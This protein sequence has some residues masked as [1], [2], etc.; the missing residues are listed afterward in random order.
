MED[1]RYEAGNTVSRGRRRFW[2]ALA[3]TVMAAAAGTALFLAGSRSNDEEGRPVPAP[4]FGP[5]SASLSSE[6]ETQ[7][8]DRVINLTEEEFKNAQFK[9][10]LAGELRSENLPRD[11]GLRTTGNIQSNAYRETAVIAL[12]GGVV[13]QVN[14][15]LGDA[16]REGQNLATVFSTELADA[17]AMY[18]KA[19]AEMEQHHRHH[20]RTVELVEIGAVSREEL[21]EATAEYKTAEAAVAS[22]KQRLVLLGMND[23]EAR[24]L[25]S[26]SRVSSLLRVT[27]PSSGTVIARSANPGLVVAENEELLR[28]ADLRTVWVVAQVYESDLNVVRVGMPATI[29][30]PAY[31]GRT[32]HGRVS[33]IAPIV[34]AQT[35][36]A[37]VRIELRNPGEALKLNMFVDV[38]FAGGIPSGETLAAVPKNA[39]QSIGNKQFVFLA[40]SKPGVFIQREVRVGPDVNGAV[41]V[42][43]GLSAGDRVVTEGSFLLRAESLKINPNQIDQASQARIPEARNGEPEIQSA[44]IVLTQSGYRPA[45]LTLRAGV[46]AKLTFVREVEATCGTEILIPRYGIRRELPPGEQVVVEFTPGEGEFEFTCGMSML[47]GKVVVK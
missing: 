10:E 8:G 2:P 34:D 29:T 37:Q 4:T 46:P 25:D 1:P 11:A 47:R 23:E 16:V 15:E 31:P 42:Y 12:V 5:S 26:A 6:V 9:I 27:A 41:A 3:L 38:R 19:L 7:P 32:F 45:S 17:Q 20:K 44:L 39:V 24:S 33:Y 30:T 18:L 21:D 36:T 40:G 28:L 13:K 43:R 14:V 22:A 35:R